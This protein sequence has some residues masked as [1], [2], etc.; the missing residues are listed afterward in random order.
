MAMQQILENIVSELKDKLPLKQ[1][2]EQHLRQILQNAFN[3]F[4]VVQQEEFEV[5]KKVLAR[6]RAKL[7]A[8]EK[9]VA[10]LEKHKK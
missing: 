3:K 10:E 6:T 1:D 9:Q 8:L 2:L 5:Q 4:E 7:E